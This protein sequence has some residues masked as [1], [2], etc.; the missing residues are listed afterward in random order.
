MDSRQFVSVV[1][2]QSGIDVKTA[3]A[4]IEAVA[5][6]ICRQCADLNT[7]AIPGF[8]NFVSEKSDEHVEVDPVTNNRVLIPPSINMQL[9]PSVILRK[10]IKTAID[11][12]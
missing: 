8:G 7:V 3:A 4:M 1:S 12:K 11:K 6:A 10:R 9:R 2:H 5:G